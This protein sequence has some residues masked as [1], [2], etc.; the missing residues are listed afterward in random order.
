VGIELIQADGQTDRQ[1]A[2]M[3]IPT[4]DFVYLCARA[5]KR[6]WSC[7]TLLHPRFRCISF[8]YIQVRTF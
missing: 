3:T 5:W 2:E 4:V 1:M 7:C 6:T 8:Q